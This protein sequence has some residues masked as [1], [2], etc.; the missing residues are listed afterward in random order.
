MAMKNRLWIV[1]LFVCCSPLSI[2]AQASTYRPGDPVSAMSSDLAK[3]TVSVQTLSNTLKAFVDKFEKVAGLTLTE[4]QQRLVLGMELLTRTEMRVSTLQ[5]AQ[6]ELTEKLNATNSKISQVDIDLR[7]RNI[8]NSTAYEGTT[9]TEEL[10]ESKRQRLQ[11]ERTNLVRLQTQ[12]QN[13]LVETSDVLRDAQ[14]LAERLRRT[15]LPQI[16]RELYDQ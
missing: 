11:T 3:I 4:K 8:N 6:I 15:F 13:N 16:E 5:K 9:E 10:R 2:L 1:F 14:S 7:P 12:L